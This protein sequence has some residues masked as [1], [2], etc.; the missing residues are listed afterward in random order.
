MSDTTC[1]HCRQTLPASGELTICPHCQ[2]DLYSSVAVDTSLPDSHATQP[3]VDPYAT[4]AEYAPAPS[5]TDP[6]C[7]TLP[8]YEILG[9]L[10]R[11]GM[12]VVYQ[13]RHLKLN[14]LAAV[15]MVLSGAGSA[16]E[17]LR[18][19]QE[20]EAV[21]RV[22]HPHIVQIFEIGQHDDRPFIAL[23]YCGGGSLAG[24]LADN[25][26]EARR[27]AELVEKL[28]RAMHHAHQQHIIHRDL[29]PANVLLTADGEPKV[30]DF[31]LA[32]KLDADDGQTRAGTIMGTPS[33]MAPEQA[34]GKVKELGPACD[35][36]ALGAIL[37]ETLTGRPPFK[38]TTVLETLE[39]VRARE[40]A[41]PRLLQPKVPRDLETICL[42]CLHK[43]PGRR[44]ASAAALAD[45]LRRWLNG[46]PIQARPVGRAERAIK[47]VKRRP[48][49]AAL[50]GLLALV[51]A[52][53]VGG[54]LWQWRVAEDE[55]DQAQRQRDVA[56]QNFR[57]A[58]E[59][60]V[61]VGDLAERLRPIAGTQGQTARAV[62]QLAS[63][64]YDRLA[65]EVG[66][67]PEVRAGKAKMLNAF[68]G[69]YLDLNDSTQ[70]VHSAREAVAIGEQLLA[71]DPGRLAWQSIL[72]ASHHQLGRGLAPQGNSTAALTEHQESLKIREDLCK[73]WTGEATMP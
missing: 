21:A 63:A 25:P 13:A 1:P 38:G 35:V 73:L 60:N 64:N 34:D 2:G 49:V 46:E 10:G 57:L 18:F 11:G 65:A 51:T 19:Q 68:S 41:A 24:L 31:G 72:A 70:A 71:T 6:E 26:L 67:T 55:R 33:Y 42:K 15:K 44:Y 45:D 5:V 52:T 61:S 58:L 8:G 47:W 56:E 29:K 28:A 9:E 4:T 39:E 7:P 66:E 27:A 16:A 32:K 12:G 37:Y 43:E 54:V 48:A 53:G 14:R 62:L 50:L 3:P 17:R 22:P 36:Y 23:E 30:T 40:P 20:A 59:T 69:L